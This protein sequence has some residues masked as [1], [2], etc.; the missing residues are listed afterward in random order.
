MKK[1]LQWVMAA[2]LVCGASV[3]TACSSDD[4]DNNNSGNNETKGGKNRQE[5]VEHTRANLKSVAE[6]LNFT[7]INSFTYMNTHLNEHLLLNDEFDKTI[8]RVFAEKIQAS[9]KPF[10]RPE[11]EPPADRPEGA[12]EPPEGAP[13]RPE[14]EEPRP[15]P[16]YEAIID[17]TDFNYTF[18][19]TTTGFDVVENADEGLVVEI[20]VHGTSETEGVKIVIKGT[21][22]TYGFIARA[23]SNDS[24]EVKVE[25]PAQYDLS[26]SVKADGK[27][28][29]Y[30]YGTAKN[31]AV[32]K[33]GSETPDGVTPFN[34]IADAWNV[35]LDLHSNIP[36]VD[37]T[38]IYFAI[39]Q[40]PSTKKA[41]LKLDYTHNA[42]K[43]LN[44]T[45]TMKNTNGKTDYSKFTSTNSVADVFTA[46]MAGNSI[47]DMN[48]TLLGCL[49]T[50]VKVSDCEKVVTLQNEM[51]EA[52][53]NYADQ[54]TIE[55]YVSQLNK[56]VTSTMSD[57]T[58][59]Q[60]I[61]MK[62]T[63]TQIGIDY[64]AVPAL[65]FADE[66]DY[67]PLTEVLDQKSVEYGLNIVDHAVDP[68]KDAIIVARQLMQAVQKLQT[69]FYQ[70]EPKDGTVGVRV[71]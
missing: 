65:K 45:A 29:E 8:S 35:A 55:N 18:T 15:A 54:K 67:V 3:F 43:V 56:L 69:L 49:T 9:L 44:V 68:A 39:G 23:L 26:F 59:G 51:A 46:I 41:G 16:K 47:E 27:W 42:Q 25:I 52:R 20:P 62:L 33:D 31:T 1:M 12:P 61:P 17:A 21:G 70:T 53:R 7:T 6:N 14:G 37:A 66:T 60:E 13:E 32:G 63:T 28:T 4:D 48:L 30:L 19:A 5:F 11:G 24:V 58:L 50:N 36:G 34:P 22:D 10:E 71:K 38:D 40:D 2:T 57:K 64:W